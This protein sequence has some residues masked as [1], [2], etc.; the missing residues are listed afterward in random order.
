[1][2]NSGGP[3]ALA[4]DSLAAN[5]LQLAKLSADTESYLQERLNSSAQVGNPVDMLGGAE[6]ADYRMAIEKVVQDPDVDLILPIL[7]PQALINPVEV[8]NVVV[9][10]TKNC[11]KTGPDLLYGR[12][13]GN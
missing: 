10:T 5:G 9:E 7:V 4:S 8:A 6:P 13:N 1:M 2:T 12:P 11:Q 3:A